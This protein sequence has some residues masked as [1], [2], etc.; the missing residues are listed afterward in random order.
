MEGDLLPERFANIVESTALSVYGQAVTIKWKANAFEFGGLILWNLNDPMECIHQ[1]FMK[2]PFKLS[3]WL[4]KKNQ[5]S[6]QIIAHK[7]G[8]DFDL[9]FLPSAESCRVRGIAATEHTKDAT[10][11]STKL[12]LA[13]LVF[14][15]TSKHNHLQQHYARITIPHVLSHLRFQKYLIR[16]EEFIIV[17]G[18]CKLQSQ[19]CDC[20]LCL[21][22]YA[23]L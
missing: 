5:D 20:A 22:L 7:F 14:F 8:Y 3:K 17:Q 21:G 9:N 12:L 18:C 23:L 10:Q 6:I 1:H 13:T 11:I 4:G 2:T 15:S 16:P 19:I